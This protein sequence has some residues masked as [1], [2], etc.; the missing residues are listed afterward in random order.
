MISIDRNIIKSTPEYESFGENQFP[1]KYLTE[2]EIEE[3]GLKKSCCASGGGCPK[4]EHG[5]CG[6]CSKKSGGCC[7]K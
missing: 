1:L 4:K 3:L 7:K 2:E 6:G 5:S